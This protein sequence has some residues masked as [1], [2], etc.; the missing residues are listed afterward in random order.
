LNSKTLA[1]GAAAG[2][3]W[4]GGAYDEYDQVDAPKQ[5]RKKK[6]PVND[7]MDEEDE[8]DYEEDVE[9]KRRRNDPSS[10]GKVFYYVLHLSGCIC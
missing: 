8:L 6:A 2:P 7:N 1:T 3:G 10:R 9:P 5:S 4:N